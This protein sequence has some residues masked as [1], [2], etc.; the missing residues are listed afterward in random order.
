[1]LASMTS[2]SE[3]ISAGILPIGRLRNER[4]RARMGV[5]HARSPEP[6][7]DDLRS[8]LRPAFRL[9]ADASTTL[10][11]TASVPSRICKRH[12]ARRTG[13][14]IHPRSKNGPATE[15]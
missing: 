2:N 12:A 15:L 1:M 4:L 10:T 3:K 5:P 7:M 14:T 13:P 9:R 11:R 8:V 6:I